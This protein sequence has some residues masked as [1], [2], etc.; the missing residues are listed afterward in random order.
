MFSLLLLRHHLRRIG[1]Y[2][3]R[4]RVAKIITVFLFLLVFAAIAAGVYLFFTRGLRSIA[5]D[6]FLR[7]AIPLYINEL[8]FLIVG[9]LMAS[10][11]L[12]SG[13]FALFRKEDSWVVATPRYRAIPWNVAR[14]VSAAALWPLLLIAI[15]AVI[16]LRSLFDL[17]PFGFIVL[18]LAV[19]GLAA[20]AVG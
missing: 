12:I 9:Y 2:F 13:L 5:G 3:R 14:E 8:F 20:V 7:V 11:A 4:N 16:A 17:T 10:S 6:P 1:R 15:P 19:V 18:G